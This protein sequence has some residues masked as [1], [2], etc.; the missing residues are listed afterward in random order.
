MKEQDKSQAQILQQQLSKKDKLLIGYEWLEA[1]ED[2][3]PPQRLQPLKK[4]N[5]PS[6]KE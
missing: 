1:T 2:Q 3:V 4:R 6:K 5:E